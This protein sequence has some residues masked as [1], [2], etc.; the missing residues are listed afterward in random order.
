MFL[1]DC[2]QVLAGVPGAARDP[3]R[4]ACCGDGARTDGCPGDPPGCGR[5]AP[6]PG[7]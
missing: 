3:V 4:R 1:Q 2:R 7:R 5:A 6:G